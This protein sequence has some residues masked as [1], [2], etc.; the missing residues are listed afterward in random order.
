MLSI[1]ILFIYFFISLCCFFYQIG[2]FA[3][4]HVSVILKKLFF[5]IVNYICI[6]NNIQTNLRKIVRYLRLHRVG[7]CPR[8]CKCLHSTL[9]VHLVLFTTT[10]STCRKFHST[11]AQRFEPTWRRTRPLVPAGGTILAWLSPAQQRTARVEKNRY[12]RAF[13]S[14]LFFFKPLF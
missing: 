6:N 1:R 2:F 9:K 13:V 5:L 10:T 11:C 12:H 7:C 14:A 4:A 8:L 3:M